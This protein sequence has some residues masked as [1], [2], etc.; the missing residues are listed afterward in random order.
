MEAMFA[1]D[2]GAIRNVS[3]VPSAIGHVGMVHS[4]MGVGR[5]DGM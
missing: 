2:V 1:R 4:G 3:M 5:Y